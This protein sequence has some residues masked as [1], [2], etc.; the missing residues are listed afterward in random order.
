MN[1]G[2]ISVIDIGTTKIV[3]I[4]AKVDTDNKIK[5]LG[6]GQEKSNGIK[7]G[8]IFNII[9]AKESIKK[10][11]EKAQ[12]MANIKIENVYIGIAGQSIDSML[13]STN[14]TRRNSE[15]PIS[16]EELKEI[17]NDQYSIP[18]KQDEQILEIFPS[19]YYLDDEKVD[20]PIGALGTNFKANFIIVYGKK[21]NIDRIKKCLNELNLNVV[22]I[23]L[24][25]L[26]SAEAILSEAEKIGGIMLIDI[27]GGTSDV[28]IYKDNFIKY[29]TIIPFGGNNITNDIK[30]L[31]KLLENDAETIKIK[32]GKAIATSQ[33][34]EEVIILKS[35]TQQLEEIKI[36]TSML[37]NIV[38]SRMREIFGIIDAKVS[39]VLN[40]KL[41]DYLNYGIVLTG[42]GAL[43]SR[44]DIL[45]SQIF[46]TISKIRHSN[47]IIDQEYQSLLL[48]PQYSTVI[49]LILLANKH[50][51]SIKENTYN[52]INSASIIESNKPITIKNN[53]KYDVNLKKEKK[54]KVNKI[55]IKIGEIF[56]PDDN[57]F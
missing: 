31:F 15:I 11:I 21:Q 25:P 46:G 37:T 18:L 2:I 14:I 34:R 24:E 32:F 44:I 26:A 3:C 30:T 52:T 51:N 35:Q 22:K 42:G 50:L 57:N 17:F 13:N 4:I 41:S 7:R 48:K 27:G 8:N 20:S 55:I 16:A 1:N 10:A 56:K 5:I 29:T 39:A 6:F 19:Q 43:L 53:E 28:I 47:V 54:K 12:Q 45:S 40:T 33:D 38:G 49:G 23:F 9:E 36:E